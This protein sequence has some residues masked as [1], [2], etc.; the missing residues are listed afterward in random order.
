MKRRTAM[1]IHQNI[2][3]LC[4]DPTDDDE[5]HDD[6]DHADDDG[7]DGGVAG[8]DVPCKEQIHQELYGA[9]GHKHHNHHHLH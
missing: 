9:Q 1:T 5:E 7:D 4:Q 8:S 2:T 3:M 6:D